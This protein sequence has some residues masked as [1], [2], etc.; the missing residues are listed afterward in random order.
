M[1]ERVK[2]LRKALGLTLDKF[3]DR[4][5]V[6][7]SAISKIER[8]ENGVSDQMLKSICR[9]FN[10]NENWLRTGEGDM[11]VQLSRDERV[12]D[13][14]KKALASDDEFVI[15]TFTALGQLTPA[16]WNLVKKF[17]NTFK[18]NIPTAAA[19]PSDSSSNPAKNDKPVPLRA[20]HMNPGATK[21]QIEADDAIMESDDF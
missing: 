7:K 3:G 18:E 11:F 17:I 4:I 6:G 9:E 10:V 5:G 21:E 12:A 14:V 8:G 2:E 15:N 1:N 20:A 13:I 16:E 19:S